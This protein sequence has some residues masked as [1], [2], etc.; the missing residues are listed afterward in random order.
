MIFSTGREYSVII[1]VLLLLLMLVVVV[2]VVVLVVLVVTLPVLVVDDNNSS[3]FSIASN[4]SED[5]VKV[6]RYS[7]NLGIV[8]ILSISMQTIFTCWFR[9]ITLDN[10]GFLGKRTQPKPMKFC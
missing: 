1:V 8:Y 7:C 10:K 6:S 3:Q 4:K 2:V 9:F 5:D